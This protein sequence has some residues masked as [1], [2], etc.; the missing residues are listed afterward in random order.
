MDDPF[1]EYL[2]GGGTC[3]GENLCRSRKGRVEFAFE[4]GETVAPRRVLLDFGTKQL[5]SLFVRSHKGSKRPFD[6]FNQQWSLVHVFGYLDEGGEFGT[7]VSRPLV[8][9][10][11][12]FGHFV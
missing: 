10:M 11:D 7:R 12:T 1:P 8:I 6:I 3:R 4:V 2:N 5:V 9:P